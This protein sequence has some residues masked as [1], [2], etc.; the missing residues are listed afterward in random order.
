MNERTKELIKSLGIIP[1]KEH[2][3][4]AELIVRECLDC[5]AKVHKTEEFNEAYTLGV[6]RCFYKIEEHFFDEK[7]FFGVLE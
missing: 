3:E 7:H 4:V 2:Y 5:I 1:E 6:A